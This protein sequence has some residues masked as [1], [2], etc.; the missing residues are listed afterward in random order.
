SQLSMTFWPSY[1]V[2]EDF[3]PEEGIA[4]SKLKLCNYHGL[5]ACGHEKGGL[6]PLEAIHRRLANY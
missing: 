5:T 2:R 4:A 3:A 1:N 6:L